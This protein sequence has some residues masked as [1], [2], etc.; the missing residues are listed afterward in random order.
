MYELYSLA[1]TPGPWVRI[2]HGA[3]L[4]SVCV[5]CA[6]FCVYTGRGLATS[7]SPIQGVLPTVMDLVTELKRKVWWRRPRPE[8]G[9]RAKGKKSVSPEQ[10]TK[11]PKSTVNQN[12]SEYLFYQEELNLWPDKCILHHD[13]AS[14]QKHI[15]DC[16][17]WLTQINAI[18][19][20]STMI[21][22]FSY[23]S[24]S[25]V[26]ETKIIIAK[27]LFQTIIVVTW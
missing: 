27:A 8:L 11:S 17:V 25:H 23:L 24:V 14:P 9:F 13:I 4:F 18:C 10:W 16:Y 7:W 21:S 2:L 22:W 12:V 5:V 15:Q 20:I 3:W 19:V 6:F 1:R 26:P